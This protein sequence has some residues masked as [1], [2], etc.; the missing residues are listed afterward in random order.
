MAINPIGLGKSAPNAAQTTVSPIDT[1]TKNIQNQ[2][3][4]KTQSLNRLST[5]SKLSEEE[6]AKERQE[7]QKQIAELNRKLRM[8]RLEKEEEAKKT[9]EKQEEKITLPE[10]QTKEPSSEN[11]V[12]NTTD[13]SL[14]EKMK[15]INVP[16]Q[17]LQKFFEAGTQLQKERIQLTVQQENEGAAKLL[18]AEIKSDKL[19]GSDTTAKEEKLLSMIKR[20]PIE[21]DV[22]EEKKPTN[23]SKEKTPVKVVIREEDFSPT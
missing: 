1:E 7:L 2:I 16:P 22:K 23:F 19:Y 12:K 21:I 15:A 5:D 8:L 14:E 11:S 4:T 9:Q 13:D 17:E 10:N 3:T 6:K 18:E 20:K